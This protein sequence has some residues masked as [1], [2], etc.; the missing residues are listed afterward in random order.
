MATKRI[1]CVR[2]HKLDDQLPTPLYATLGSA[3]MDVYAAHAL[4]LEPGERGLV[5]LGF[6]MELPVDMEAQLRPRSGLAIQYGIT[7]LNSPGTIDSD[8]REE[9]QVLLINHGKEVFH[10]KRGMRIAQ[11]VLASVQHAVIE[12]SSEP[13]P[14]TERKGGLGST[15]I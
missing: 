2:L 8:F 6:Q 15:G 9:V 1:V 13:L 10:V 4:A 11:M 12:L 7:V 5:G 3:G 14:K